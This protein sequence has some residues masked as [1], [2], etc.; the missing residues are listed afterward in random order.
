MKGQPG[1]KGLFIAGYSGVVLMRR[2]NRAVEIGKDEAAYGF[3][4]YQ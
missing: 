3:G 1:R 2:G 4:M